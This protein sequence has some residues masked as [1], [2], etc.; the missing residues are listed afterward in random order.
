[1]A[2][3]VN[4]FSFQGWFGERAKVRGLAACYLKMDLIG[5][6]PA[7]RDLAICRWIIPLGC[8]LVRI[9]LLA[10]LEGS[11]SFKPLNLSVAVSAF[12]LDVSE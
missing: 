6:Y 4:R 10:S 1:M 12:G 11:C 7:S 3:N 2:A 8:Y 9:A 5:H